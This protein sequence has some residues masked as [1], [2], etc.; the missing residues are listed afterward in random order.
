VI[1]TNEIFPPVSGEFFCHMNRTEKFCRRKISPLTD[2]FF[3]Y[4]NSTLMFGKK[5]DFVLLTSK[6]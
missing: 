5:V 1:T 4:M 3:I 6:K 2:E